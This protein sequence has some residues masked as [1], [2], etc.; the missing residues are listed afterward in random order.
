MVMHLRVPIGGEE[1]LEKLE[2][3]QLLKKDHSTYGQL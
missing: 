1:F 2:D 3:C